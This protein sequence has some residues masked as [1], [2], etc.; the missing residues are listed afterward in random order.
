MKK[1]LA[2]SLHALWLASAATAEPITG[3]MLLEACATEN[4]ATQQ[5]FCIGYL[6]G[7]VEGLR[8]GASVPLFAITP[9]DSANPNQFKEIA[10]MADGFLGFC[11][12]PE[13]QYSQHHEIVINYLSAHPETR[14]ESARTQIQLA[15][16]EA[17]P[18]KK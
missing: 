5:G 10:S 13:A 17:F 9:L 15:L 12:P 2:A 11:A 16:Q 18:C 14:H 3:N 1:C 8:Y 6:I 4:D 7:V